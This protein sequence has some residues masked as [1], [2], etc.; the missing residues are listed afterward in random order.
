[1]K[2]DLQKVEDLLGIGKQKVRI[3]IVYDH[4]KRKLRA[5]ANGV[6]C[7]FPN[8]LR[9]EGAEYEAEANRSTADHYK[10]LPTT[11]T[12]INDIAKKASR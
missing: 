4:Q 3:T 10:V 1:M 7:Q 2:T 12:P 8:H 11:I 9:V 6:W 5:K